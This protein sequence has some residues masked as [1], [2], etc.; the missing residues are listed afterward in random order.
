MRD[1]DRCGR[2]ATARA[3]CGGQ[4]HPKGICGKQAVALLRDLDQGLAAAIGQRK[5]KMHE[6]V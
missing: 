5:R 4:N 3:A 6:Q 2:G 1:G